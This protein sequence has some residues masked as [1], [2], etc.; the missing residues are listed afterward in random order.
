MRMWSQPPLR[1]GMHHPQV[2]IHQRAKSSFVAGGA[3]SDKTG[4][5][6]GHSFTISPHARLCRRKLAENF[7][8]SGFISPQSCAWDRCFRLQPRRLPGVKSLQ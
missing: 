6:R 2:R 5:R 4:I 8:V 1:H 3:V 7:A